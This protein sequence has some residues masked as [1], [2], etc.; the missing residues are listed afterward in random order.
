LSNNS[1]T[2]VGSV[3]VTASS[4]SN[5]NYKLP[6]SKTTTIS[7]GARTVT[8]TWG[9]R[10]WTYDKTAHGTTCTAGNLCSGDTCT[11]TLSN[12][13]VTNVSYGNVTVT[14]SGLSNSNYTLPSSK[15]TTIS[16]TAKGVTVSWGT[17][18]WTYDKSAHST[19]CS[20]SSGVISGDTCNVTLTGNSVGANVGTATVSASLSN[21]NYTISSGGTSK[22]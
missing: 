1:I 4:L 16:V 12:N 2:N 13:S 11:V 5:S 10:S 7:I 18:S 8:L 15:T 14:A 6:S 3:T 20:I 9:T 19:T 17:L 21:S 22:H